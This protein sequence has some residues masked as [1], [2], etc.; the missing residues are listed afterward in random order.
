M[1]PLAP[2]APPPGSPTFDGE[3]LAPCFRKP[4]MVSLSSTD[5]TAG[6]GPLM[7]LADARASTGHNRQCGDRG[8]GLY[9]EIQPHCCTLDLN[10]LPAAKLR[11]LEPSLSHS[12]SLPEIATRHHQWNTRVL[13]AQLAQ[14][15]SSMSEALAFIPGMA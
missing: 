12:L 13:A 2:R 9:T 15:L 6:P 5:P 1:N 8:S 4:S 14:C 3:T 7:P 10:S 11:G